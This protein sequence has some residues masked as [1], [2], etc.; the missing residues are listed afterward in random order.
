LIS[1]RSDIYFTGGF[2][3]VAWV[4]VKE[5]ENAQPDNIVANGSEQT[6]K[7][8]PIHYS[9]ALENAML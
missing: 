6:L 3:T 4:D 5:F 1:S 7:V 2:G 8:V 9:S